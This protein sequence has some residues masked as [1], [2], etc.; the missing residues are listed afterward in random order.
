MTAVDRVTSNRGYSWPEVR[1]EDSKP[2]SGEFVPPAAFPTLISLNRAPLPSAQPRRVQWPPTTL[3]GLW[4][5]EQMTS[6]R[7]LCMSA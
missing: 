5:R 1:F 3:I 2:V 4:W 6:L 7:E